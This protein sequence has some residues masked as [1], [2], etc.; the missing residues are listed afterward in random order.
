MRQQSGMTAERQEYEA[1][2]AAYRAATQR[3]TE[4]KRHYDPKTAP[5]VIAKRRAS[6]AARRARL[7]AER[8]AWLASPERA[9]EEERNRRMYEEYQRRWNAARPEAASD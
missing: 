8:Q 1:A 2:L 4:A 9:A 7:R 5:E 6:M 3:L